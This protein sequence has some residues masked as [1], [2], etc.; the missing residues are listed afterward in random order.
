[1]TIGAT[2]IEELIGKTTSLVM[3]IDVHVAND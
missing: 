1:M 3:Q 2:R